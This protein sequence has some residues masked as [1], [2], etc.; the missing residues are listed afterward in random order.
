[1]RA[2]MPASPLDAT[3]DAD[4]SNDKERRQYERNN[5]VYEL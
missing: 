4:W 1:M 2:V 5:A 3:Q